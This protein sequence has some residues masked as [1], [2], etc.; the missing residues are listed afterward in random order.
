MRT[1]QRGCS[2]VHPVHNHSGRHRHKQAP[3]Q[4]KFS[5][6]S[7]KDIWWQVPN[8]NRSSAASSN[9][10]PSKIQPGSVSRPSQAVLSAI[11]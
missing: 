8:H 4:P 11:T 2:P 9:W 6:T 10:Y 7:K 3:V 5:R 1:R